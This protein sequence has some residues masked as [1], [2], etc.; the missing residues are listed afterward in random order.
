MKPVNENAKAR[1]WLVPA[2]LPGVK[3]EDYPKSIGQSGGRRTA[4][5]RGDA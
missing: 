3:P 1:D 2:K 5:G 4:T